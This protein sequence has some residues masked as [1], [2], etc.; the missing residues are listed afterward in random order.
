MITVICASVLLAGGGRNAEAPVPGVSESAQSATLYHNGPVLTMAGDE[1]TFAEALV[2]EN[3]TIVFV[4][5]LSE[6]G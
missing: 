5:T 6:A 1:P 4:G 3:G 2:E